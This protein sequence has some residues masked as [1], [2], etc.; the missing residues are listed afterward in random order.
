M[1]YLALAA[2]AI[3]GLLAIIAGIRSAQK[4]RMLETLARDQSRQE[5][6]DAEAE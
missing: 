6:Q 1:I 4:S 2:L 5:E 3:V